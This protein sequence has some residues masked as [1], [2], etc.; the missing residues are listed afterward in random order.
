MET[1]GRARAELELREHQHVSR[2]SYSAEEM[3]QLNDKLRKAERDLEHARKEL[4]KRDKSCEELKKELAK[5]R[6]L[7]RAIDME[8]QQLKVAL[9]DETRVKI[10]LFT[11]LSEAG[12]K[13][14]T[15]VDEC[16][17][18]NLEIS[19]LRQNLAEIMAIIPSHP[20]TPPVTS[21][22]GSVSGGGAYPPPA[23]SPQN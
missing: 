12:R 2:N 9:A 10:E 13:Q 15:L 23:S 5:Q 4:M 8:K 22:V 7:Y 6:M 11:A 17:R 18:K 21:S 1:E 14:Q 19:R 20:S 16:H 3:K